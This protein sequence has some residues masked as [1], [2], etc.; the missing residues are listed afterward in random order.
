MGV[1]KWVKHDGCTYTMILP[2]TSG[3]QCFQYNLIT[4]GLFA[5][6]IQDNHL[7]SLNR[8]LSHIFCS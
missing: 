6:K 8:G 7:F 4:D 1:E 5:G 2:N 3:M